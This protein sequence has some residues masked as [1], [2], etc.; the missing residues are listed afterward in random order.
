MLKNGICL[1]SLGSNSWHGGGGNSSSCCVCSILVKEVKKTRPNGFLLLKK[2]IFRRTKRAV[3][4]HSHHPK[5]Q[6]RHQER[7]DARH[8][9]H[10]HSA[11]TEHPQRLQVGERASSDDQRLIRGAEHVEEKPRSGEGR[12]EE[13]RERVREER[14]REQDC[15]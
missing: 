7:T 2:Q 8:E 15:Y 12:E 10:H 5:S 13:E 14:G 4:G 11:K 1:I 3:H 9:H 6:S